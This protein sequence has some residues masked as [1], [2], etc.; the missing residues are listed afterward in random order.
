[1]PSLEIRDLCGPLGG[2]NFGPISLAIGPAE[3]VCISG[4]SGSGKSVFLRAIADLD[5]HEGMAYLDG[6]A[7][8]DFSPPLWRRDVGFLPTESGWWAETVGEHFSGEQNPWLERLGFNSDVRN[9]WVERLSTGERHRL[10]F[11]RLLE[12]N[13]KALLLDEPTASLDEANTKAVEQIVREY[14]DEHQVPVLWVSHDQ[15]QIERIANRALR[16][17]KGLLQEPVPS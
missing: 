17:Q 13:P 3:C 6:V 5:P 8:S 14:R 10:A 12:M 9:W 15:K 2:P 11:A 16:I 7:S 4:E 1:M